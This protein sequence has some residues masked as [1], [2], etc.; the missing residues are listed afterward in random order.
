VE[1]PTRLTCINTRRGRISRISR[2]SRDAV[3]AH[4]MKK[5][6]NEFAP[7]PVLV[8]RLPHL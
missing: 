5:F 6:A 3:F 1:Q 8:H 7:T 4:P 2:I